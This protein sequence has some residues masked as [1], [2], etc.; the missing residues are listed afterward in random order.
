MILGGQQGE[1]LGDV[2]CPVRGDLGDGLVESGL[3]AGDVEDE[4]GLADLGDLL[5]AE[6]EVMR[7]TAG[8]R[9]VDDLDAVAADLLRGV[10]ERVEP[11]HDPQGSAGGRPSFAVGR[12]AS[13]GGED[14]GQ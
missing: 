10:R 2:E 12:A 4:V 9:E 14:E 11:R 8:R 5:G 6:L 7:L 3:E 1:G 13:A